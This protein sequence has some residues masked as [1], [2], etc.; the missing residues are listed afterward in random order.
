MKQLSITQRNKSQA[1]HNS[2]NA[3]HENVFFIAHA[4][5]VH[6]FG[7]EVCLFYTSIKI[8]TQHNLL[9]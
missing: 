8:N 5:V 2:P 9:I 3:I 4:R 7:C 1:K 6:M